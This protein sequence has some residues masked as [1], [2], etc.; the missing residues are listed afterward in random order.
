M[1]LL[2]LFVTAHDAVI[3]TIAQRRDT[4]IP[5]RLR[6]H[7]FAELRGETVILS[8]FKVGQATAVTDL[9]EHLDRIGLQGSTGVILMTDDRL[10]GLV[11]FLGDMFSV[12]RFTP[13]GFGQHV[14]NFVS[15]IIAKALRAFRHYMT[16]FDDRKYQTALRVPLRNFEAP[17]VRDLRQTCWDMVG[18]ANFGAE[19]DGVLARM[20]ARQRPKK[21]STSPETYLVDDNGKHFRLGPEIHARA[22][23][24]IPPHNACCILANA[25]RFGRA[26]QGTEHFNVSRDR[27]APMA[28]DYSDCHGQL[29]PGG[30]QHLNMFS[31]DFF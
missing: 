10:P 16:R 4:L 28:G 15:A 20:R 1:P 5:E 18:R 11:Q 25:F 8:A 17:E 21:A 30:G 14:G 26:F 29:R 12:N 22:E 31:N 2:L 9:L 7:S 3:E 13:P 27:N 24:A 23:S 6:R 19:L